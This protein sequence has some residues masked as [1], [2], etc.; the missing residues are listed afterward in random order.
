MPYPLNQAG[1][2]LNDTLLSSLP[3]RFGTPLWVYDAALI[4]RQ[5]SS[6]A[7][8]TPFASRRKPALT[9]IFCA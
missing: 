8:S 1:Y 5:I 7:P 3:G 4:E 9:C 6:C 2:A